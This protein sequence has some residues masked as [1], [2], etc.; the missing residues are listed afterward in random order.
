[1][2]DDAKNIHDDDESTP[3]TQSSTAE[4]GKVG[5]ENDEAVISPGVFISPPVVIGGFLELGAAPGTSVKGP[6]KNR[7][8]SG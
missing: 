5:K 8:K 3:T 4:E 2:S 1:M 7:G 6:K